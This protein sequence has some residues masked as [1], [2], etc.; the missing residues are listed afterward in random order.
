MFF[1]KV[2]IEVLSTFLGERI[3]RR[4]LRLGRELNSVPHLH[5]IFD[6]PIWLSAV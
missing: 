3:L 1:L 2:E 4:D 6:L 5:E